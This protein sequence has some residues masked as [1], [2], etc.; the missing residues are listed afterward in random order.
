MYAGEPAGSFIGNAL[1]MLGRMLE[2]YGSDAFG[3]ALVTGVIVGVVV[4][5]VVPEGMTRLT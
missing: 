1:G 2:R 3:M 4:G 5:R